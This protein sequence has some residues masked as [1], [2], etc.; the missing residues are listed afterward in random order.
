MNRVL[1]VSPFRGE[2]KRNREYL[3]ECILDCVRRGEAPFA[4]HKMYTDSLEDSREDERKL[5]FECEEAWLA[6]ADLVVV[7]YDYGISE[8]MA[9]TIQKATDNHI[10]VRTRLLWSK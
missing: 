9:H 6:V 3:N 5:G 1:L 8:G 10:P 4:S 7:Y 2:E